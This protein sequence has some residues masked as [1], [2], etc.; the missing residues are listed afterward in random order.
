MSDRGNRA[1]PPPLGAEQHARRG[2]LAHAAPPL[3]WTQLSAGQ[4]DYRPDWQEYADNAADDIYI[5]TSANSK[6]TMAYGILSTYSGYY[7]ETIAVGADCPDASTDVIAGMT[8]F[9]GS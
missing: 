4:Y 1:S 9:G 8:A 3:A 7:Q 5:I 2:A 6:G